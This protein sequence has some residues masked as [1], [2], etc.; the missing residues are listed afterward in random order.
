MKR[1]IVNILLSLLLFITLFFVMVSL[2]IC[3]D[4]FVIKV[5][6]DN[7]YYKKQS[8]LL[9]K[10][11]GSNIELDNTLFKE[12]INN[13]VEKKFVDKKYSSKIDGNKHSFLYNKYVKFNNEFKNINIKKYIW[14]IYIVSIILVIITGAIFNRTKKYHDINNILIINFIFSI[15]LA[16]Y[17]YVFI[18]FDLDILNSIKIVANKYYMAVSIILLEIGVYNKIKSR[19]NP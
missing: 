10:E 1:N 16:M 7:N 14:I 8:L 3:N 5:L 2:T 18:D 19:I 4:N 13:Y 9:E 15:I 11:I 6:E 17:I 12:D